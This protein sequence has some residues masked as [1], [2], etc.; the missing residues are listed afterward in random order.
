[1]T[2]N[3]TTFSVLQYNIFFGNLETD[4]DETILDRVDLLCDQIRNIDASAVCLQE[5]IPNRYN[6]LVA[7]LSDLYPFRFP[8][9]ISQ[10]YDTA[11]LSKIPIIETKQTKIN[12]SITGMKRSIMWIT[13]RSPF[14][15]DKQIA[16][17]TSHFES[18][19]SDKYSGQNIKLVQYSEAVDILD[20][21]QNMHLV[22][23]VIFCADFNSHNKLS[24]THLYKA[25][26]YDD[27]VHN[28]SRWRDAW[29]EDGSKNDAKITFDTTTNPMMIAMH[30]SK[31]TP[32]HYVSRLDRIFHR[33][34]LHV[35]DFKLIRH[36]KI[37]SDHYPILAQFQEDQKHT[38]YVKYDPDTDMSNKS[39]KPPNNKSLSS[40]LKRVSL[41]KNKRDGA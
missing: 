6:Y 22:N 8:D 24:N 28:T 9:K 29:M 7:S 36:N 18:E 35:V 26:K 4:S 33:S 1:M 16:I 11:I 10:S 30:K 3:L 12:Y 38:E 2:D 41:F 31:D 5:V 13:I 27:D 17:A 23:D 39:N 14:D 20:S 32:P 15:A 34:N 40:K 37:I 25:F 19:F 21:L